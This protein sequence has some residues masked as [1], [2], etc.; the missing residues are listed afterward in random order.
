MKVSVGDLLMNPAA[1][2]SLS[3][4]DLENQVERIYL[5]VSGT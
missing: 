3:F 2:T 1:K 4:V 5:T